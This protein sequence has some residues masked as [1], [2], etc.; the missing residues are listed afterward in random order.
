MGGKI[1]GLVL[2]GFGL[3]LVYSGFNDEFSIGEDVHSTLKRGS[4]VISERV[5]E[6]GYFDAFKRRIVPIIFG[7]LLSFVGYSVLKE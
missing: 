3:Y 2:L 6:Y 1:F 4:R 5:R 7:G